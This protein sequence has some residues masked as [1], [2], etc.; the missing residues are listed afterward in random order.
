MVGSALSA[1]HFE[2]VVDVIYQIMGIAG[3]FG[4]AIA[5]AMF[6]RADSERTVFY[7]MMGGL[8]GLALGFVWPES[9][10]GALLLPFIGGLIPLLISYIYQNICSK[11]S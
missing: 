2:S 8:L 11:Q 5:W 9:I 4:A 10:P 7:S 1:G 6:V 3:A